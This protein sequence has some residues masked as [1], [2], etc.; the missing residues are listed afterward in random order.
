MR[1]F[2]KAIFRGDGVLWIM[3]L[4]LFVISSLEMFSAIS[5]V[6]YKGDNHL[7]P[8]IGHVRYLALGAFVMLIFHHISYQKI[9]WFYLFLLPTSF[10]LLVITPFI[11]V[12]INGAVRAI[13]IIGFEFQPIELAKW[14]VVLFL[15]DILA[16]YQNHAN[17]IPDKPFWW[18]IGV[19]AVICVLI[20]MQNLSTAVILF[21]IGMIMM[22][23]GRVGLGRIS[24]VCAGALVVCMLIFGL[25]KVIPDQYLPDR[26][27]SGTWEKRITELFE[28]NSQDASTKTYVIDDDNRQIMNS[29]IAIAKGKYPCGPGNSSQ[30][31]YL[32][33][34]FSDFI[35]A[36]LIEEYGIVGAALTMLLYLAILF[37]AGM[38]AY[39]SDTAYPAI[40]VIGLSLLI[41][42]QAWISMAVTAHLGPV[43][44]QPL[45]LISRG[46]TSILLTCIYLGII[47]SVSQY[48]KDIKKGNGKNIVTASNDAEN[49]NPKTEEV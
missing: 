32:P 31:D 33:L 30:R 37:R 4:L 15:S 14:S 21:G 22:F 39:K 7:A 48:V 8:F 46:G 24:L 5:Q 18:M 29:K 16:R 35:Y 10:V 6:A 41:V 47:L 2:F 23:V 44:G 20:A 38:I 11:G 36:I 9:R 3:I 17:K 12:E 1:E 19:L 28:E 27:K 45:P 42:V 26:M 34:A 40:L 13:K 25:S 49:E 43:T